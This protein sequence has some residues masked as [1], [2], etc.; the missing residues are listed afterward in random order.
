[1][2]AW[3]FKSAWKQ[4]LFTWSFILAAFQN[5]SIFW[6]A[7]VA[8]SFRVVCTWY[9]IT[10]LN[11]ISAKMTDMKSIP[12]LTFKRT[13][14][15]N[16]TSNNLHLFISFRVNYIHMKISCRFEISFWSK[17]PIWNP[18]HFEFHL[19]SC[20]HR[21]EIFNQWNL[22]PVWFDFTPHVNILKKGIFPLKSSKTFRFLQSNLHSIKK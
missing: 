20:G 15:E 22:K 3:D 11:F 10:Q 18:Y 19:N 4:G 14:T 2:P 1:M 7:C 13:C 8:I 16:A 6:W 9:F 21:S 12:A 17:W 5:N